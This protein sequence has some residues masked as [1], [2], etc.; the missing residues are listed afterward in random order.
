MLGG[1]VGGHVHTSV[2]PSLSLS[3]PVHYHCF[4]WDR[5]GRQIQIQILPFRSH[6]HIQVSQG[7][8]VRHIQ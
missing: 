1:V 7:R 5:N 2:L 6:R 3:V 4:P 8:W